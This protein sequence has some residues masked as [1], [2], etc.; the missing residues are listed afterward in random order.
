MKF[1]RGENIKKA[2][3]RV[4][5]KD[6]GGRF[7]GC[8][9]WWVVGVGDPSIWGCDQS[10]AFKNHHIFIICNIL[11]FIVILSITSLES[12][13]LHGKTAA[14]RRKVITGPSDKAREISATLLRDS[15]LVE[16]SYNLAAGSATLGSTVR[17]LGGRQGQTSKGLGR[18]SNH[19][20]SFWWLCSLSDHDFEF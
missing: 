19:I 10:A 1:L 5:K 11:S 9:G 13:H 8:L 15:T 12:F 16:A 14:I 18:W 4:I 3:G 20:Y 7:G 2:F 17:L 6:S